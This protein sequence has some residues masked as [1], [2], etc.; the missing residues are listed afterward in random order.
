MVN[1][2]KF[3]K[4]PVITGSQSGHLPYRGPAFQ[5]LKRLLVFVSTSPSPPRFA[6]NRLPAPGR[7]AGRAARSREEKKPLT[8]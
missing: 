7:E 1:Y 2:W 6:L 5:T 8:S 4:V 3:H